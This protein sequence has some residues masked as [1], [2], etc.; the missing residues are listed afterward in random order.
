M[1]LDLC[2]HWKT[3]QLVIV[4]QASSNNPPTPTNIKVFSQ[5]NQPVNLDRGSCLWYDNLEFTT[6]NTRLQHVSV[7]RQSVRQIT[8]K[9]VN[10]KAT[11]ARLTSPNE[12]SQCKSPQLLSPIA[13]NLITRHLPKVD[14]PSDSPSPKPNPVTDELSTLTAP[15]D[16]GDYAQTDDL[17]AS[18]E[19]SLLA[20]LKMASSASNCQQSDLQAHM[21]GSNINTTFASKS[22]ESKQ[23]PGKCAGLNSSPFI[24]RI[25]LP[26]KTFV[27]PTPSHNCPD[28][29][30][31]PDN[32]QLRQIF[33]NER[34]SDY[35][36]SDEETSMATTTAGLGSLID[37]PVRTRQLGEN[38]ETR[39]ITPVPDVWYS[40][41][42][43]GNDKLE[44]Y[45]PQ[46]QPHMNQDASGDWALDYNSHR[47]C[48][49]ATLCSVN[50]AALQHSNSRSEPNLAATVSYIPNIALQRYDASSTDRLG[51]TNAYGEDDPIRSSVKDTMLDLLYDSTLNCYYDPNTETY[52]EL[53]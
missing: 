23:S 34:Y 51:R 38:P 39:D 49:V 13:V 21:E 30:V 33:T 31:T 44:S 26:Q 24:T 10:M 43:E 11:L 45:T 36:F 20:S 9:D 22:N 8:H 37:F 18:F 12:S 46:V 3:H 14:L 32:L 15:L 48:D 29:P 42:T 52:Y 25:S 53:N 28:T 16:L 41:K 5:L 50:S 4:N 35:S 40:G 17:S 47:A 2:L 19:A 1:V 7:D 27:P 6:Q